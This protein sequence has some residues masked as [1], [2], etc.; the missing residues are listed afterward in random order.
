VNFRYMAN[1]V[2]TTKEARQAM[3]GPE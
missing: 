2:W 1:T 3:R